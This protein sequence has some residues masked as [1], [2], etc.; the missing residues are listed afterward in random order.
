V[1]A[2]QGA[3]AGALLA[4]SPQVAASASQGTVPEKDRDRQ[5]WTISAKWVHTAAG[6]PIEDGEVVVGGG[7][8]RGVGKG[9]GGDLECFA[10]TPGLVDLSVRIGRGFFTVEQS[11]EVTP[12][13]RVAASFD[14]FDED[15]RQEARSGVTTAMLNP[16]DRN[17]VG[18]LSLV[19]KTAGPRSAEARTVKADSVL[20]GAIGAAPSSGNHPAFGRP[21]DFYSRRPTTRMGVEWEWRKALFDAASSRADASK[22]GPGTPELLRALD[23]QVPLMIQAWTTQDIRTAVF[24]VEEMEREG[25]GKPRLIVD[26]AAE[27]WREPELLVRSKAS[28]VLPPFTI[29]GRTQEGAF[30][31]LESARMLHERGVPVALSGHG[32]DDPSRR[33]AYQ[34][35]YAMRGG[36]PFDA[37]LKAVTITPARIVGVDE[38]VG[39]LENGKDA[40]LVLWSGPPFEPSSAVVG[41]L[42]DG[43]LIVDPRAKNP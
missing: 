9:S 11:R 37:A 30:F 8:I 38:R 22:A 34:P 25:L 16:N 28:V 10:V 39:S 26:A 33:L 2:W 24:L 29:S 40:D 6:D 7:K 1:I 32:A 35:G 15:W 21:D 19:V 14:P 4:L 17:V 5:D 12:E 42:I 41:V 3:I 13:I 20:Y 27:A 36:L 31:A 23:G 18:G 43:R